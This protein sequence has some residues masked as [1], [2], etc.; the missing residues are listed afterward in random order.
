MQLAS[1][2]GLIPGS[3]DSGRE[4]T[5]RRGITSNKQVY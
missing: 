4:L 2:K 5:G 3:N 1:L